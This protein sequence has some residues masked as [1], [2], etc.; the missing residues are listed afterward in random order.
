MLLTPHIL[1]DGEPG[2]SG[3]HYVKDSQDDTVQ[4]RKNA[5]MVARVEHAKR[6]L[7]DAREA[8]DRG[9]LEDARVLC[10]RSLLLDPLAE[11]ALELSREIDTRLTES[12]GVPVQD[13][14]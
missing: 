12:V 1:E 2:E 9:D 7:D 11:G 5:G 13:G 8:M 6:T 14:G 10:D 4:M 3:E